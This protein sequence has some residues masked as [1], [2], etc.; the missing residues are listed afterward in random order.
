MAGGVSGVGASSGA[1]RKQATNTEAEKQKVVQDV[2]NQ[3]VSKMNE[4][5]GK[6]SFLG[7]GR[8][9]KVKEKTS[10]EMAQFLKENPNATVEEVKA[11]AE[12][13]SAKNESNAA[14]EKMRDDNFFKKLMSRRKE[15]I[16]DMWG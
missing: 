14:F 12:E 11:K 4:D 8:V 16:Q 1:Q 2:I 15:L 6:T 13:L 3:S 10:E 5:Q 9:D 7:E